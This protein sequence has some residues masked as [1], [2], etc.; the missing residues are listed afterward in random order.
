MATLDRVRAWALTPLLVAFVASGRVRRH[1]AATY[2]VARRLDPVH[3][4]PTGVVML[5]RHA[6]ASA[7]LREPRFGSGED[8]VDTAALRLG[9]L[10]LIGSGRRGPGPGGPRPFVRLHRHFLLFRDPP[11]HTRIRALV[12]KAFTPRRVEQL[13]GRIE[14]IVD[15]LL[16]TALAAGHTEFMSEVAYPL[17]ARVI[18]ELVG[19]PAEDYPLF[20]EHAPGLARSIDPAPM[21]TTAAADAADAAV[22]TL[23]AYLD[24]LIARRREAPGDDLLS[25]LIAAEDDGATLSHDELVATVLL[26]V[27]A[28]HETTANVLGNAVARLVRDPAARAELDRLAAADEPGDGRRT[29]LS[30]GPSLR[31]AVEEFL[32]LDGPVQIAQR[33]TRQPVRLGGVDIPA[34][35]IVLVMLAAANRDPAAFAAPERLDLGRTPNPHLAFGSGPHYCIGAP[36]ARLE[37]Q[38]ALRALAQ[39]LPPEA[40]ITGRAE[41]R[42]SFT[43][44]GYAM[45]P[46][47]W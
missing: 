12:A 4:S 31:T 11:D 21:L 37:L 43:V 9:L 22:E 15:E 29:L 47:A 13:A 34:G 5:S 1:S 3:R 33:I 23:S 40:R 38:V 46:L 19:V 14:E 2:R 27:M 36:L 25:A 6:E 8:G 20:V 17:P 10:S 18:C 44:R 26:L 41:V 30:D 35:R 32:R 45:L 42:A 39:R 28:G 7:V 24:E 16:D